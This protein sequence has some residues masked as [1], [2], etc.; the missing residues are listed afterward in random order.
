MPLY[1]CK[2][3]SP[4][5]SKFPGIGSINYLYL[6]TPIQCLINILT[7]ISITSHFLSFSKKGHFLSGF[8]LDFK[9][10]T[11]HLTQFQNFKVLS[12]ITRPHHQLLSKLIHR[13]LILAV[14]FMVLLVC[15]LS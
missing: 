7:H 1:I 13:L 11:N 4:S 14:K 12:L 8:P 15:F 9:W 2:V 3:Y 5:D 6:H 10:M